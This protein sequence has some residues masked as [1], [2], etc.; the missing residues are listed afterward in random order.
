M[1]KLQNA[2]FKTL[3]ELTGAGATQAELL[4]TTKIYSSKLDDQLEPNIRK[5]NYSATVDPAASNDDTENYE[6]GSLWINTTSDTLFYCADNSTGAAVW[7]SSSGSSSGAD[8][9]IVKDVKTSGTNGG[10]ST[11]NTIHTRNLNTIEYNGATA[12]D[13][14]AGAALGFVSISSDQLTLT[15]AGT[16]LLIVEC[17]GRR[18]EK[19]Q[20]FIYNTGT[21]SYIHDGQS[22][23]LSNSDNVEGTA[24]VVGEEI[25]GASTTYE[26]RHYVANGV[27]GNGLGNASN[28]GIN[29][30][31]GEVYT[32]VTIIK[33]G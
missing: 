6:V 30:Q 3:A 4:N 9:A 5:N 32:L 7:Q 25:I 16:Y 18:T 20:A 8:V 12:T 28:N 19:T 1:G 24:R 14:G 13:S 26:I 21:T 2:D 10:G 15:Q 29:P 23:T 31:S 11:S 33:I 22:I 17:P 27:G